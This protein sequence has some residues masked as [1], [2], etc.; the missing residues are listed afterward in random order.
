[1]EYPPS[2]SSLIDVMTMTDNLYNIF[3][4]IITFNVSFISIQRKSGQKYTLQSGLDNQ[5][6]FHV[7][8]LYAVKYFFFV[9]I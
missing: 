8:K 6:L 7:I 9:F 5:T 4:T 3:I 2:V 1:M